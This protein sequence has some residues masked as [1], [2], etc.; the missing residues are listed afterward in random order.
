[1]LPGS[2]RGPVGRGDMGRGT[3][4]EVGTG[5]GYAGYPTGWEPVLLGRPRCRAG[6]GGL[7]KRRE[8]GSDGWESGYQAEVASD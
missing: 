6:G 1:V 2:G 5:G 4:G 8:A 3:V 7:G